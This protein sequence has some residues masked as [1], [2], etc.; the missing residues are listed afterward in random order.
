[1]GPACG[2]HRPPFSTP[3]VVFSP[4]KVT[5]SARTTSI[6]SSDPR[7]GVGTLVYSVGIVNDADGSPKGLVRLRGAWIGMLPVPK[8]VVESRLQAMVPT[9]MPAI[10]EAIELQIN[11]RNAI[12]I[13]PETEALIEAVMRGQPFPLRH[14]IDHR[15]L[16]IEQI[17]VDDGA[18]TVVIAPPT[19]AAVMPRPVN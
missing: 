15:Q 16:V 2:R 10:I 11:A 13:T 14:F 17:K 19:P 18:L 4:D 7:G 6:P 5:I 12:Q 1:M 8:S 3:F 9:L